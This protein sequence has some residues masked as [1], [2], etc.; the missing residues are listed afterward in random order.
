MPRPLFG[1]VLTE[2]REQL[3][4]E[5]YYRHNKLFFSATVSTIGDRLN[6]LVSDELLGRARRYLVFCFCATV[7]LL[8]INQGVG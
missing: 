8:Q 1:D 7:T 5:I 6:D 2:L 4:E 3:V